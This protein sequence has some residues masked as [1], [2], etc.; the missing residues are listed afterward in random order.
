MQKPALFWM[1]TRQVPVRH[2]PR[3]TWLVLVRFGGPFLLFFSKK[4]QGTGGKFFGHYLLIDAPP[5]RRF[6]PRADRWPV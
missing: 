1:L 6:V 5:A 3:T 2:V 4:I